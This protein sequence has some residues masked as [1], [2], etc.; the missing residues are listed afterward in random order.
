MGNLYY[1]ISR[2]KFEP[3]PGLEPRTSGFLARRSTTSATLVLMPAHVQIS[4]LRRMPLLPGDAVMTL[5]VTILT[6]S[7][8][9][10]PFLLRSYKVYSHLRYAN[11]ILFSDIHSISSSQ[12]DPLYPLL[13]YTNYILFT[14]IH[15]SSFQINTLYPLQR[16]TYYILYSEMHI[17]SSSQINTLY[18]LHWNVHYILF[19]EKTLYPLHRNTHILFSDKHTISTSKKYI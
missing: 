16:N 7:E 3:E 17:I 9:T 18:S 13:R 14:E 1:R 6:T 10:S 11:Y 8:L 12:I 2:E 15:I 4:L 19:Q 5:S